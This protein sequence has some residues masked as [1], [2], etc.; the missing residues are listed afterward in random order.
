M[1]LRREAIFHGPADCRC[2]SRTMHAA[3]EPALV[4]WPRSDPHGAG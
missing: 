2:A 1:R 4:R 3:A